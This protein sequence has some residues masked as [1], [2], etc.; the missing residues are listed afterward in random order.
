M[1]RHPGE[2]RPAHLNTVGSEG[3][4]REGGEDAQRIEIIAPLDDFG[5]LVTT[6]NASIGAE[7]ARASAEGRAYLARD[8]IVTC[9]DL[10]HE[11]G[12]ANAALGRR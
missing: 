10:G 11:H 9:P 4:S 1:P 12:R 8:V 5:R 7:R 2:G 3:A 6:A